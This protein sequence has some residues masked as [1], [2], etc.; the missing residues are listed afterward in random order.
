[1]VELFAGR[2]S[3][4]LNRVM[5]NLISSRDT[6]RISAVIRIRTNEST[7]NLKL[8]VTSTGDAVAEAG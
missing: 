5:Q 8:R 7:G 3:S 4:Y 1:M 2:I 6:T